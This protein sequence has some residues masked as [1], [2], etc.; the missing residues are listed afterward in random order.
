MPNLRRPAKFS[1]SVVVAT[2]LLSTGLALTV[3][4]PATASPCASAPA[5]GGGVGSL[6][7]PHQISTLGELLRL[8]GTRGDW[9]GGNFIQTAPIDLTGCAWAPIGDGD[10]PFGGTYDG[11]SFSIRGFSYTDATADLVGFFGSVQG[12]IISD[13]SLVGAAVTAKDRV[14]LLIGQAANVQLSNVSVS[15]VVSGRTAVGGL[16]GHAGQSTLTD[17]S[18]SVQVGGTEQVGGLVGYASIN[19]VTRA[20][21]TGTIIAIEDNAGGLIGEADVLTLQ[22]SVAGGT[23]GGRDSVG[24]LLGYATTTVITVSNS[25]VSVSGRDRVG[26]LIGH[27]RISTLDDSRASGRVVA[28]NDDGGGLIGKAEQSTLTASF[29][30]GDVNVTRNSAGGLIGNAEQSTIVRSFATGTVESMARSGGLVGYV[31]RVVS[32]EDSY[33][34][35][36]VTGDS[37]V[38]GLVG[39]A[40]EITSISKSYAVGQV[41]ADSLAGGLIGADPGSDRDTISVLDSFW[42]VTATGQTQSLFD[43]GTGKTTREMTTL[44]TYNDTATVGLDVAWQISAGWQA[45]VRNVNL[46][47]ICSQVNRG[48]PF[49]L[50]Q[51]SSDPC[52]DPAPPVNR[53][54]APALHMELRSQVGRQVTGTVV[55][56]EGQGLNPGS[57]Y[58]LVMRSTPVT[59]KADKV[60]SGGRFSHLVGLPGNLPPGEH[61]LT[62]TAV[63]TDGNVLELV[64]RFVVS[65]SGT[66]LSISPTSASTRTGLAATGPD[67]APLMIGFGSSLV[68]VALGSAIF[69]FLRWRTR[70]GV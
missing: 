56:T 17:V 13:V 6:E 22:D 69:G 55:L 65:D 27:S 52:V 33:A 2:F 23:V 21:V 20:Q 53:F 26:G 51:A 16:I 19:V 18:S 60:S 39:Y 63:G 1:S 61:S 24:G 67:P 25:S 32:I 30:S 68:L 36:S 9:Q 40:R 64:T 37:V 54:V 29:A 41:T 15:G 58:S 28:Q 7:D 43:R 44:S 8:S 47:G 31:H 59:L 5:Y 45:Y 57:D 12:A 49:L 3:S 48:Y 4:S 42:D 62:L 35:G 66:F 46:W 11:Q 10:R 14:G 50:W 38:G 34:T 70:V